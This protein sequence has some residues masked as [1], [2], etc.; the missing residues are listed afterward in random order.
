MAT[1]DAGSF[2]LSVTIGDAAF[3]AS[4]APDLVMQAFGDFKLLVESPRAKRTVQERDKEQPDAADGEAPT[5]PKQSEA[6]DKPLPQVVAAI[7]GNA[8]VATAIVAWAADHEDK[9]SL[10]VSEIKGYWRRTN[11]RVP[12]NPN[13]DVEKAAKEGWLHRDDSNYTVTGFGR[14][15]VGLTGTDK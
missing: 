3:T 14:T 12:A 1:D 9:S 13:R 10:T 2:N 7:K 4:G 6:T 8:K 5:G 11:L 15:E